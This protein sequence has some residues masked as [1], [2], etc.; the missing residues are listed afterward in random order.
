LGS[1]AASNRG[2][3]GLYY[4][5]AS[6]LQFA[7]NR[8]YAAS[9]GRW[10]TRDPIGIDHAFA[11]PARFNATDLNL[12]AYAGNNP[13]SMVDPSG[14]MGIPGAIVGAVAGA[15]TGAFGAFFIPGAS[16]Y[17]VASAA[18]LGA[19]GGFVGGLIEPGLGVS[20][21]LGAGFGVLGALA[22][23]G[24]VGSLAVGALAGGVG[25]AFGALAPGWQGLVV[26][27]PS[28]PRSE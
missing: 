8:V 17:D 26:T 12:Y 1:S 21:G 19:A 14:D 24:G 6:G 16:G 25:G 23:G 13:Q 2:F 4:H 9:L 20:A 15:A 27:R 18:I 3:T 11:D 28:E 10:L 7:R 22:S 5:A